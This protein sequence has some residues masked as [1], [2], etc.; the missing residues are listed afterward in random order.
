MLRK[1]K[2]IRRRRRVSFQQ[3]VREIG[4]R[5]HTAFRKARVALWRFKRS[6]EQQ[7]R[8]AMYGTFA[9]IA[10]FAIG[11][12]DAIIT[13]GADFAPG[14]AA[15]AAEYTPARVTPAAQPAAPVAVEEAAVSTTALKSAGEVDYSFTTE[16]L[17]GGPEAELA[18][19]EEPAVAE[20][21]FESLKS[22]SAEPITGAEIEDTVL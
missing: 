6:P 4:P 20:F 15:Y 21:S 14:S 1:R 11:S 3:R 18:V 22:G 19:A 12:V 7:D 2:Q 13:G 16:E 9:F 17:L 10:L 8:A 5:L